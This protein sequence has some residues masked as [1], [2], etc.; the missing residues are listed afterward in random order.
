M[1]A[2]SRR[3]SAPDGDAASQRLVTYGSLAPGRPN[4]HLLDGLEGRWVEGRVYGT[5]VDAGWGASL[6][7]PALILDP[8]GSAIDVHVF[9]SADLPAH[10]ARLDEFE[11]S[12]YD[13]VVTIVRMPAGDMD[14]SIYVLRVHDED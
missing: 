9:E 2:D 12:G 6:G 4:H 10:W 3:D 5:L 7:Y 1:D 13:R 14:A 8:D 11:G